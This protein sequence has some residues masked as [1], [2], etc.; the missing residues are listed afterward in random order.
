MNAEQSLD[1]RHLCVLLIVV[2]VAGMIGIL[3]V[4]GS[5]AQYG[6]LEYRCMIEGPF[7][8]SP[9]LALVTEVAP[10]RAYLSLWP[11]GRACDWER[12]DGQGVVTAFSDLGATVGFLIC[13]AMAVVGGFFVGGRREGAAG[14]R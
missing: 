13:A 8:S 6:G 3:A 5:A 4:G 11:F 1:V 2:G 9:P 7:P 14:E 12:A 10:E